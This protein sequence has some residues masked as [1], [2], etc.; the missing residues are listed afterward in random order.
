MEDPNWRWTEVLM[1]N[2]APY[3]DGISMHYYTVPGDWPHKGSATDF[4]EEEYRET[5]KKSLFIDDLVRGHGAI[6][7]RYD[8]EKRI[9]LIVDEWGTWYDVEPG[10]NPGF[11]YQQSTM[12]DAMVAGMTLNIFNK[13]AD[14]VKMA[15]IAQAVNVLQAVVLTDGAQMVLTPTCELGKAAVGRSPAFLASSTSW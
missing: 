5:L 7:D 13:H 14:R 6:M 11:L 10:T 2:A 8:P 9:G 1:A 12:R 3:M 15:N 4:T